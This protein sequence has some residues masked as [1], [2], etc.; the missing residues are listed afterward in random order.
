MTCCLSIIKQII[1]PA[2]CIA[3]RR[4]FLG[5]SA[6]Y[7]R[8]CTYMYNGIYIYIPGGKSGIGWKDGRYN[9]CWLDSS[10]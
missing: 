2:M 4:P 6:Y 3:R 9:R 10:R 7:M 5:L 8:V 1:L